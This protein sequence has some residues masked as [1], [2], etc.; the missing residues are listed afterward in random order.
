KSTPFKNEKGEIE[1]VLGADLDITEVLKSDEKISG[2]SRSLVDVNKDLI[3]AN[4]ELKNFS[5]ITAN[6][7]TESLRHVYINLETIVTND[8]R[9]LSNSGRA[10]LRRA[11]AAIQKMKLLSND[12]HNYLQLYDKTIKKEKTDP[13]AVLM[14][15]K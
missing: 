2:L 7:Y 9:N 12:I 1:K 11:Q 4:A 3:S 10:N 15:I 8:A 6:N 14:D 5:A 13:N